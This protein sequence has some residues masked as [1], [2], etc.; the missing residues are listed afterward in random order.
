MNKVIISYS[1]AT[2]TYYSSGSQPFLDSRHPLLVLRSISITFV[3]CVELNFKKLIYILQWL[4]PCRGAGQWGLG[5]VQA[6]TRL[7]LGLS[8]YLLISSHPERLWHPGWESLYY[9]IVNIFSAKEEVTLAHAEQLTTTARPLPVLKLVCISVFVYG[10][11]RKKPYL[12]FE[13]QI[14]LT[15]RFRLPLTYLN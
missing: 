10:N 4:H 5:I 12:T 11:G 13:Y 15:Q 3:N 6:G 8:T 7:S 1:E 9:S 2:D 14:I